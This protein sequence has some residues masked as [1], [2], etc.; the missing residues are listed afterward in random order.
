MPAVGV[1]VRL[2]ATL[3]GYFWFFA[4]RLRVQPGVFG[5]ISSMEF[6][7]ACGL[8]PLPACATAGAAQICAPPLEAVAA[9]TS[10]PGGEKTG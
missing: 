4:V 1:V 10:P 9:G 6:S 5:S 2:E 7:D 3:K 8:S